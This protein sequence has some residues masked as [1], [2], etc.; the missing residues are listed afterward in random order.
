MATKFAGLLLND[1]AQDKPKKQQPSSQRGTW[2]R[3][4]PRPEGDYTRY[5]EKL[6][7][8]RPISE[9]EGAFRGSLVRAKEAQRTADNI[10][11]NYY[12]RSA[13]LRHTSRVSDLLRG[14]DEEAAKADSVAFDKAQAYRRSRLAAQLM[15]E[16]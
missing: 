7:G 14:L 12:P 13:S 5:Y 15:G 11:E 2:D 9:E 10:S 6:S 16:K 3:Q 8:E 4:T 1:Q